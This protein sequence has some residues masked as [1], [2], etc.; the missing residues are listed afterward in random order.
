MRPVVLLAALA[1]C[2]CQT[3]P[4]GENTSENAENTSSGGTSTDTGTGT[5]SDSADSSGDGWTP[6]PPCA[7]EAILDITQ[8][9]VRSQA[10]LDAL[11]GLCGFEGE[12]YIDGPDISSLEPLRELQ[13]VKG[14][15][16]IPEAP[17]VS[18]LEPLSN[19]QYVAGGLSIWGRYTAL[20]DL[21]GLEHLQRVSWLY[22]SGLPSLAGLPEELEIG[23]W[24]GAGRSKGVV[25]ADLDGL[26]SLE[27]LPTLVPLY[28]SAGETMGVTLRELPLTGLEGIERLLGGDSA[29]VNLRLEQLPLSDLGG[30]DQVQALEGLSLRRLPALASLDGAGQLIS[31]GWLSMQGTGLESFAGLSGLEQLAALQLGRDCVDGPE[32]DDDNPGLLDFS[33]LEALVELGELSVNA[34]SQLS[35]F[36]GLPCASFSVLRYN[37]SLSGEVIDAYHQ[38]CALQPSSPEAHNCGNAG[39][40]PCEPCP[41]SG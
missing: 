41:P 24:Q 2:G 6:P 39:Q 26:D 5:D 10:E 30:L 36:E 34:Q 35:S 12:L 21:H 23:D 15:F 22:L 33:G 8:L 4:A 31:L 17:G 19:L 13:W 28:D 14:Y 16:T 27:Q 7:P 9:N 3:V 11:T 37:P 29:R 1:L 40:D 18:T 20:S 38:A 32:P 25:F